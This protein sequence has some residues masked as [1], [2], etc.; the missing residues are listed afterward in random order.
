LRLLLAEKGPKARLLT[1]PVDAPFVPPDLFARL[2]AARLAAGSGVSVVHH[3]GGLHPVFGVWLAACARDVGAA[4]DAGER[5]LHR[6]AEKAAAVPC[7]AWA[8][9]RPDPFFNINT[10]E[11]LSAAEAAINAPPG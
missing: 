7:A 1:A 9:L 8:G 2:E 6:L 5:A 4:F 11:D 3:E 10:P